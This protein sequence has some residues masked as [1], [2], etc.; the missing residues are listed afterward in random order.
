MPRR[1]RTMSSTGSTTVAT[2][3]PTHYRRRTTTTTTTWMKQLC[4]GTLVLLG[5][6]ILGV[7][8]QDLP[9][10]LATL[11]AEDRNNNGSLSS[12]EFGNFLVAVSPYQQVACPDQ[13]AIGDFLPGGKY[14]S[15]FVRVS[16][17]CRDFDTD[18][19]CCDRPSIRLD[20]AYGSEYLERICADV[21]A[22]ISTNCAP[23]YPEITL[24][25]TL[26]P[27][28]SPSASPTV[29]IINNRDTIS[30]TTVEPQPT[31]SPSKFTLPDIE[32]LPESSGDDDDELFFWEWPLW[33]QV[34][35]PALAALVCLLCAFLVCWYPRAMSASSRQKG[36][37][38]SM[39]LKAMVDQGSN[40]SKTD[41]DESFPE[42]MEVTDFDE[43]E[44]TLE[45]GTMMIVPVGSAA[46]PGR[47]VPWYGNE[48]S[49]SSSPP[50]RSKSSTTSVPSQPQSPGRMSLFLESLKL[51][52]IKEPSKSSKKVPSSVHTSGVSTRA[53]STSTSHKRSSSTSSKTSPKKGG[54]KAVKSNS[55]ASGSI[56]K[57][58]NKQSSSSS[59]AAV[60][61]ATNSNHGAKK[62]KARSSTT[63]PPRRSKTTT[64]MDDTGATTE[65]IPSTSR[66]KKSP[67]RNQTTSPERKPDPKARIIDA[68]SM[69]SSSAEVFVD[70]ADEIS[71]S[72]GT[73][74][75]NG[76]IKW[77][78]MDPTKL[79]PSGAVEVF[80]LPTV[81]AAYHQRTSQSPPPPPP[82]RKKRAPSKDPKGKRLPDGQ[83]YR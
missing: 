45:E 12:I 83:H 67:K 66:K 16:C 21:S 5:T 59:A 65:I 6:S 82:P 73:V 35:V 27:T 58:A 63:S 43:T 69:S 10:C 31:A 7:Q 53:V 52:E 72:S 11:N 48:S 57:T 3:L 19:T 13:S 25:P 28:V 79:V 34:T 42:V 2:R 9:T 23:L 40:N 78:L 62:T 17:F 74:E 61:T 26:A 30:P 80:P 24:S 33:A 38:S 44:R 22:V 76:H 55:I 56:Q 14:H 32:E 50:P 71:I 47:D 81:S 37:Q 46:S 1:E 15:V 64:T 70:S 41:I 75:S 18:L 54:T 49:S 68:G 60:A 29:D 4:I 51:E 77:Q 8:G 36:R 39:A 20:G